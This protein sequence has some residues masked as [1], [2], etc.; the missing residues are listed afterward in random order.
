MLAG[1]SANTYT[2][3][4]TRIVSDLRRENKIPSTITDDEKAITLI[5]EVQKAQYLQITNVSQIVTNL[6]SNFHKSVAPL[7]T[8]LSHPP[9]EFT[10]RVSHLCQ[11][12]DAHGAMMLRLKIQIRAVLG[13]YELLGGDLK[14][15][16]VSADGVMKKLVGKYREEYKFSESMTDDEVATAVRDILKNQCLVESTEI[17]SE[18]F[19][20]ITGEVT[21]LF[22]E[23]EE[24]EGREGVV[25]LEEFM[26]KMQIKLFA[27]LVH[28]EAVHLAVNQLLNSQN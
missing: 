28:G 10:T 4:Q 26:E 24:K 7:T 16:N 27:S 1:M 2:P 20:K 13:A 22:Q 12:L 25:V 21:K 15:F 11:F 14:K 8:F 5:I 23:T 9:D 18:T 6:S 19:K 17:V 3:D